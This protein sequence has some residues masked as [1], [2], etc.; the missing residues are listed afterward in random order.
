MKYVPPL[1]SVDPDA[2]YQNG[3]PSA[4]I[5]GSIVPAA[6]IEHPQ[7]ELLH[8]ILKAGL[9][10]DENTLT[11]LYEA[12]VKIVGVEVPLAS[13]MEAGL[14][15]IGDGLQIGEDGTLSVK[16]SDLLEDWRKSWIG[17]P[18]YW[19]STV[20]PDDHCWANGDFISFSN[21]PELHAVYEAGGLEG[22]LLGWDATEEEQAANLGKWRPDS[23]IP[24]GLYTPALSGQFFRNWTQGE[25]AA[26]A[27][28]QPG[29][30]NAKG[31]W[32]GGLITAGTESGIVFASS[33]GQANI[34]GNPSSFLHATIGIDLSRGSD[35]YGNADT[36]MPA[37]INQ[38]AILYL[39]RPA[40][41]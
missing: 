28:N 24:T 39:G 27:T 25:E 19:R 34:Q 38:P 22:M 23:S 40:Q 21:W 18:R 29:L 36:V 6:A 11:Q 37:S 15:K 20:L 12:I 31:Q 13:V 32:G 30:P 8:V 33:L 4:G 14:V 26:G 3:N 9:T 2:A 7:R 16:S 10:P 17:V 41:V 35:I 5:P 1:G